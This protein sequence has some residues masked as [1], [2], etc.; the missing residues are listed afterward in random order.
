MSLLPPHMGVISPNHIESLGPNVAGSNSSGSATW[1]ANNLAI[2][3][4][5]TLWEPFTVAH[6]AWINGA[7]VSGNVDMGI[8]DEAGTRLTST[9]ATAQ[10]GTNA[11]QTV[12]ITDITLGPGLYYMAMSLS[13]A[14]GTIFRNAP[15]AYL[16]EMSGV[17][18]EASAHPLPA[19]ATF[20]ASAQ[21]YIPA[22]C[23][24]SVSP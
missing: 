15:T 18:E 7:A 13:S 17:Y 4:P 8:Y 11:I 1:P 23:I 21:T 14:V 9:G 12:G 6:L 10:S 20:A 5:F 3:V 19:T 16:S 24:S 22:F 2:Y